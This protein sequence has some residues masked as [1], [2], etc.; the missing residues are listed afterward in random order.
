MLKSHLALD[1]PFDPNDK[2][3]VEQLIRTMRYSAPYMTVKY[4]RSLKGVQRSRMC[5]RPFQAIQ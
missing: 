3:R 4:L 5:R 1:K 2:E